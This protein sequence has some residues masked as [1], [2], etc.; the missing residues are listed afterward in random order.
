MLPL[1]GM[2]VVAIE[3]A[4]A[5]PL[6][7]A[8]LVDAGARVIKIERQSGDFARLYDRAAGGESSY[9]TWLNHG[10]Q[11]LVLDFKQDED[12]A[13]L[14]RIIA[15]ADVLVQNLAP[16]AMERA[17]FGSGA[18]RKAHPQ[19]ITCDISGYGE[20]QEVAHM[21]A[22]DLL[23]QAESGLIEISGGPGEPGRIGISLCD[24]GAGVTA[25]AAILEALLLRERFGQGSGVAISLFDVAAEWM[26]V[27]YIHAVHGDGAPKRVGLH[28]PSIAPYGAYETSDG[29]KTI[30]SIQNEREWKR[31]CGE[32]LQLSALAMDSRFCSN[33]LRVENRVALDQAVASVLADIN[34]SEFRQRLRAADIAHAGLNS[35]D[36]LARHAALSKRTIANGLGR[37]VSMPAHPVSWNGLR[38]TDIAN[39]PA[40]GG[41]S[42][43][44]REEFAG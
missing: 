42:D 39:V 30:L 22:Y 3:Q 26:S 32:V 6:C 28:H 44:I 40:I 43:A 4:V 13:L 11:S 7:T 31:L 16:G 18:L 20:R 34:A 19:L 14:H 1:E 36:D 37:R 12:A 17:G 38:S 27:P 25:H 9:F 23:V 5:A 29:V 33:T 15:R 41:D 10:K 24:I 21:K 8:R 35:V 2:L